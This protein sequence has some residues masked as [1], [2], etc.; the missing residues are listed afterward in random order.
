MKT[1]TNRI[2]SI[3]N[4]NLWGNDLDDIGIVASMNSLEVLSLSVNNITTLRDVQGCH[5]LRELYLRKNNITDINEV[6]YLQS[7][8]KLRIVWLGENPI[9]DIPRYRQFVIKCLP[10][11]EKLDNDMVT[12][13]DKQK[14]DLIDLDD[15]EGMQPQQKISPPRHQPQ[16]QKQMPPQRSQTYQPQYDND[17]DDDYDKQHQQK[18]K[19][20]YG[21]VQRSPPQQKRNVVQDQYSSPKNN[22]NISPQE[23]F[24]AGGGIG[25][26]AKI[27]HSPKREQV[28]EQ[29]VH[30]PRAQWGAGG[31]SSNDD[32]IVQPQRRGYVQQ[33]QQPQYQRAQTAQRR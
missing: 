17:E 13:E 7:L 21:K 14:A 25:G 26:A 28:Y 16:Q 5:N 6:R 22:R 8:R 24:I 18:P 32:E 29:P 23:N 15:F 3:K 10:Q 12:G 30:Q 4:L 19:P 20:N 1:K 33:Q 31:V 2:E 27:R 11:I 9:A